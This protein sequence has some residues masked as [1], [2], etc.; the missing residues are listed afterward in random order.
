MDVRTTDDVVRDLTRVIDPGGYRLDCP[1]TGCW[2][3]LAVPAA[4]ISQQPD[5]DRYVFVARGVG[6]QQLERT[7]AAH[8]DWHAELTETGVD[9]DAVEQLEP[10][11]WRTP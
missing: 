2:W 5:T 9:R 4:V 6:R 7:L 3:E 10:E 11:G 8:L 1:V